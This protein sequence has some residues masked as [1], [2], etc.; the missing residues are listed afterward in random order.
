MNKKIQKITSICLL[1]TM[2]LYTLPVAAFTKD[3][4]VYSNAKANGEKYKSIVTTHLENTE[5]EEILRDLTDLLNIENTNGDE[6]FHQEGN[7]L[8]WDAN[9]KDIYYKGE[10]EKELPIEIEVKYELNGEELSPEEIAGKSG[11]VKVTMQFTNNESNQKWITGRYETIYTPFVVAAGTYIDNNNNKNIQIE[12][13]KLIDDGS[14][15][16]AIGL[17]FPGMQESLDLSKDIYQ[18]PESIVITMESEN[19][20]MNNI[21][22]YV[23]PLKF[24]NS[25]LEILKDLNNIYSQVDKLQ[26]ASKQLQ[27]GAKTLADGTA[28]YYQKSQEFNQAIGQFSTGVSSANAS[29]TT[30]NSGIATLNSSSQQLQSGSKQLSEGTAALDK[31]VN[32]MKNQVTAASGKIPELVEGAGKVS[33][34]L[35]Q[36]N[37]KLQVATETG[38]DPQVILAIQNQI[39]ENKTK[40]ATIEDEEVVADL[41]ASADYLTTLLTTLNETNAQ[42]QEMQN[43]V[44]MLSSGATA[45]YEGTQE[46][47]SNMQILEG[48]LNQVTTSTAQ[49]SAGASGLYEGT[50]KLS[51]GTAQIKNG[52]NQMKQGLN[53]LDSSAKA[54]KEADQQLTQGAKT[55]Q[56]GAEQLASG[57]KEFNETGINKICNYINNDVRNV[58]DRIQILKD[59]SEEYDT[60]TKTSEDTQSNVKFITIVDSIKRTDNNQGQEEIDEKPSK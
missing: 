53:T 57:V 7:T 38:I 54:I 17:A 34:G 33:G 22:N 51:A 28:T 52:S 31:G 30:I 47:Q 20:E 6:T 56:D 21:L 16:F 60:F 1:G 3:E 36:L 37:S 48:G 23:T 40:A 49:L 13:G 46:V 39:K 29:Y 18:I 14:K 9:K 59:L 26:S 19:F 32:T 44:S 58:T 42:V 11:E 25:N 45:V 35:S 15:T 10:T 43:A 55:I 8:I 5:E 2:V 27:D 4:T 50:V 41:E 12:N 24:D